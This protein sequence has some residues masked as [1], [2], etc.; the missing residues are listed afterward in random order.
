M[1]GI[2]G[3]CVRKPGEINLL[4]ADELKNQCRASKKGRS[5]SPRLRMLETRSENCVEWPECARLRW[6][7][8]VLD[9]LLAG[10]KKRHEDT[11]TREYSSV[12]RS[13]V[14]MGHKLL[15]VLGQWTE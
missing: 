14:W 13:F 8:G 15:E 11:K 7:A 5:Q 10:R 6:Y 3:R 9:M 1:T 2:G 4:E 12:R